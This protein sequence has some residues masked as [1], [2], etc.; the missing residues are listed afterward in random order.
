MKECLRCK[1]LK[2]L[3]EFKKHK[4]RKDGLSDWCRECWSEYRSQ[5]AQ[6][7]IS[8]RAAKLWRKAHPEKMRIQ[9]KKKYDKH[10]EYS[11]SFFLRKLYG[12]TIKQY[13]ELYDKQNGKCAICSKQASELAKGLAVDHD[14]K[15]GK[16]RGLLCG[17]CNTAIGSFKENIETMKAAID[18]INK[19]G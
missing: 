17:Y 1:K 4:C 12:I 6:R 15:T 13:N 19:E 16:I 3:T 11:R 2:S 7:A 10:W 9:Y 18:Y 14:H 8:N 5:P